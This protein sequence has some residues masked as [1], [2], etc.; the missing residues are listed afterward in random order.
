M[1]R[2][3]KRPTDLPLPRRLAELGNEVENLLARRE[4]GLGFAGHSDALNVIARE[5]KQVA[6]FLRF[7]RLCPRLESAAGDGRGDRAFPAVLADR[8]DAEHPIVDPDSV[9][10][11]EKCSRGISSYCPRRI[12]GAC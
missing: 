4:A 5:T 10:L 8:G 6:L 2:Q 9:Q 3:A 1:P 7:R 11:L 12:V